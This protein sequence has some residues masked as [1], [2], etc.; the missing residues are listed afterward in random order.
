M[1]DGVRYLVVWNPLIFMLV[2]L[3]FHL[4]APPHPHHLLPPP[5]ALGVAGGGGPPGSMAL[6][7]GVA[8]HALLLSPP[9]GV[10][11]PLGAAGMLPPPA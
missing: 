9:P 11:A 10:L 8:G 6:G 7:A 1:L 3:M 4:F 5:G 2:S